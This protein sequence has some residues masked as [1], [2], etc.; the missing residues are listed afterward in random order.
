MNTSNSIILVLEI[1]SENPGMLRAMLDVAGI[2]HSVV[3]KGNGKAT[4]KGF[5]SVKDYRSAKTLYLLLKRHKK[6]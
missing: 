4:Y 1:I 5:Q 6:M 2:P 3:V